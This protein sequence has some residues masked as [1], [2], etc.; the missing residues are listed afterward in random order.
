MEKEHHLAFQQP[1][2][3]HPTPR[4]LETE[5]DAQGGETGG[6]GLSGEKGVEEQKWAEES[7]PSEVSYDPLSRVRPKTHSDTKSV[8][9]DRSRALAISS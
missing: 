8:S 9:K 5:A 1:H 7:H 6:E 2:R 3:S 4:P